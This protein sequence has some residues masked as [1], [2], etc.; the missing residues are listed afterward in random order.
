[1]TEL[2]NNFFSSITLASILEKERLYP[3]GG[4]GNSGS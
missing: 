3:H 2:I 4:A 1:M